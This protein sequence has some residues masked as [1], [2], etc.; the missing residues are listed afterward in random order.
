MVVSRGLRKPG[1]LEIQEIEKLTLK[2]SKNDFED[3]SSS[4]ERENLIRNEE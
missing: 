2:K 4:Q 3:Q 1:K